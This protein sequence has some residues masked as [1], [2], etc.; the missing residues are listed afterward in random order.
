[1]KT[2]YEIGLI[3]RYDFSPAL[4]SMTVVVKNMHFRT[5]HAF[6]KGS[7]EKIKELCPDVPQNFDS[8]Y[9]EYTRKG[10]RVLA[11]ATKEL[12][13]QTFINV[14]RMER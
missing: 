8:V 4:Q 12:K 14:S 9:E 6:T 11:I 2:D 1:M 5:F 10:Y 7:P 3:Q 13:D